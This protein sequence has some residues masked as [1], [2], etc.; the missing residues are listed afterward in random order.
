MAFSPRH[1]RRAELEKVL[2]ACQ[3]EPRVV[4]EVSTSFAAVD[5]AREGLGLSIVNPFPWCSIARRTWSF[6]PSPPKSA[7]APIM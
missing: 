3:S 4:A 1:A 2:Q 7:T 5:L 6:A